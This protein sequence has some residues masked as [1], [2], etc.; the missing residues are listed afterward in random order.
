VC[1]ALSP[2]RSHPGLSTEE[3]ADALV[4]SEATVKTQVSNLLGKLG[5]AIACRPRSTRTRAG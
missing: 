3:I 4:L 5:L 1:A 2:A